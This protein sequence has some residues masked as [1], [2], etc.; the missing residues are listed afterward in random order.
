MLARGE[1][2][3]C[4]RAGESGGWEVRSWRWCE[5]R[6]PC[7]AAAQPGSRAAGASGG[8]EPP[9]EGGRLA[10]FAAFRT[11]ETCTVAGGGGVGS[12]GST[13]RVAGSA[14]EAAAAPAVGGGDRLAAGAAWWSPHRRAVPPGGWEAGGRATTSPASDGIWSPSVVGH[15][16]GSV[17]RS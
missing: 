8:T 6:P 1:G 2:E 11:P 17:V 14:C 12:G 3:R 5:P 13:R 9:R 15:N 10:K 4:L 7:L 16:C